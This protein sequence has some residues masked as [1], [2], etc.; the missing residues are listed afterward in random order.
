MENNQAN[1]PREY[2]QEELVAIITKNQF[3]SYAIRTMS[4]YK[5]SDESHDEVQ[6]YN[7][8]VS[9]NHNKTMIE[10]TPT[11]IGFYSQLLTTGYDTFGAEYFI[12]LLKTQPELLYSGMATLIEAF[13]SLPEEVLKGF[14]DAEKFNT[15]L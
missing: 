14:K 1:E 2:T 10:V 12:A 3:L 13:N 9:E 5:V 11:A 15:D 8:L 6:L 7:K 4:G